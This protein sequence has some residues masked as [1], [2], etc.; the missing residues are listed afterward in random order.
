MGT[1]EHGLPVGLQI[2]GRRFEDDLVLAAAAAW[3]RLGPWPRASQKRRT[4]L[5][6]GGP[7][8]SLPDG[9]GSVPVD[10]RTVAAAAGER[11]ALEADVAEIRRVLSPRDAELLV[12]YERNR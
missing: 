11:I 4:P 5:E 8:A 12:E 3:E 10:P 6:V 2:V 7:F 1:A 9:D